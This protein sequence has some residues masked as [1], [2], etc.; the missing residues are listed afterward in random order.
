MRQPLDSYWQGGPG[1]KLGRT[2]GHGSEVSVGYQAAPIAYDTR[3][4]ADAAGVPVA[5]THLRFLEQTVEVAW[6]HIWD[7][8]RQWRSVTRLGY[9][10]NQDNG[11]GYYDYSRYQIV[12]QLRFRPAKW[13][14]SAQ[15]GLSYY[16][17]PNQPAVVAGAESRHQTL[18][19]VTVHAERRLA[20]HWKVYAEYNYQRS[21]SNAAADEYDGNVT[22]AGI[23]FTF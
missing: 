10:L 9:D 17:F 5:N 11:S 12:E 13:E 6:Q 22:S 19:Q 3:Q 7:E 15:A 16:E 20:E 4:Q 23:E 14:F 8:R 1:L 21:L 2:Y 18:L